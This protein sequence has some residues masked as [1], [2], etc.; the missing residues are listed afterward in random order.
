MNLIPTITPT[1]VI[2]ALVPLAIL[3]LSA[4][5]SARKREVVRRMS[6]MTAN[7]LLARFDIDTLDKDD[8]NV[9]ARE[10]MRRLETAGQP[11]T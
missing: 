8:L 4:W 3:A 10:Y 5:Y 11:K 9:Y 6:T 1:T 7:E 2:V